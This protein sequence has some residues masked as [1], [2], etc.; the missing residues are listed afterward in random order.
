MANVEV[1][2]SYSELIDI[3]KLI[4]HPKNPNTHTDKQIKLLTK[5]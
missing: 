1:N 2:C 5:K 4:P 3:K